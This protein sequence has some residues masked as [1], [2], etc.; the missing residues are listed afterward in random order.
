MT[1]P[2]EVINLPEFHRLEAGTSV[3]I[4][5]GIK[6]NGPGELPIDVGFTGTSIT[7]RKAFNIMTRFWI[8]AP[9]EEA[10]PKLGEVEFFGIREIFL[11]YNDGRL[12]AHVTKKGTTETDEDI[13][14]SMLVAIRNFVQD[15]FRSEDSALRTFSWSN[16]TVVIEK[17]NYI[18]LAV[19]VEG[20]PPPQLSEEMARVME[21]IEGDYAGIIEQWDGQDRHFKGIAGYLD[22]VFDL[23]ENVKMRREETIV[24][25]KSG[26]EFYRGFVRLKV[27][28]VNETDTVLTDANLMLT[29]NKDSLMLEKVEPALEMH[30]SM[31]ILGSVQPKEK[32]TVAYYLDPIICQES[33][34][35][36]TLT[37]KDYK[38]K[39]EHVDMKRRPVDIV[40]PLFYT[41]QTLNIAMLKRLVKDLKEKDSKLFT[42]GECMS[43]D[44]A[45]EKARE[46]V[47]GHDVKFVR[48]LKNEDKEGVKV[49]EGWFYGRVQQSAEEIVIKVSARSDLRTLEVYVASPNLANLTGLL[50]ELGHTV[51]GSI[52]G[53]ELVTDEEVKATIEKEGTLLDKFSEAEAS[54]ESTETSHLDDLMRKI[55]KAGGR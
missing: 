34:V 42:V 38:G 28:V 35:D 36:C 25:V 18:F 11:I 31:V 37:Y 5:I 26:L 29:Y 10:P 41:P 14:S 20:T 4:E 44:K 30:G 22:P 21:R 24:K 40:C 8:N 51:S 12:L 19:I 52:S 3:E 50:A 13:M 45:Y 2:A 1:G 23:A 55:K 32:K 43:I 47:Q 17:G 16:N 54:A 48:E 7:T 46:V 6:P 49:V 39:L 53:S 33:T 15:S 27:A 9:K